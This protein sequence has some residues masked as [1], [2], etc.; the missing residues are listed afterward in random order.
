MRATNQSKVN[1]GVARFT[2]TA[3]TAEL[4]LPFAIQKQLQDAGKQ[5]GRQIAA[6]LRD[7][8]T[9]FQVAKE[10]RKI[11]FQFYVSEDNLCELQSWQASLV[12]AKAAQVAVSPLAKYFQHSPTARVFDV[13]HCPVPNDPGFPS[14][15]RGR[16]LVHF[17]NADQHILYNV[18]G[19][20]Y[21]TCIV[22]FFW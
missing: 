14:N 3:Q 21:D 18:A 19:T 22:G 20:Y 9:V 6:R 1:T 10:Q 15:V 17:A 13:G 2:V 16:C 11:T 8:R 7:L 4:S 12:E 5:E